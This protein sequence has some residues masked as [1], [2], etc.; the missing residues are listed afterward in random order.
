LLKYRHLAPIYGG[1]TQLLPL[2]EDKLVLAETPHLLQTGHIHVL[3]NKT[4]HGVKLVNAGAWQEQT[5]YQKALGLEPAVG[6]A[7]V[8]NISNM[9]VE[10][11]NFAA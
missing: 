9:A 7:A 11:R 2:K 1:N 6:H 8:V 5:D 3:V 10:I 4:Y